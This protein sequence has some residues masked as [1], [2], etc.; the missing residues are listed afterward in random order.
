[1]DL[2]LLCLRECDRDPSD[3]VIDVLMAVQ[4]N[5]FTPAVSG[6]THTHTHT[7]THTLVKISNQRK[8]KNMAA[9]FIFVCFSFIF[10]FPATIAESNNDR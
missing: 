6:L 2:S 8:I 1:M 4:I 7:H 9:F 10:T 5:A 3:L